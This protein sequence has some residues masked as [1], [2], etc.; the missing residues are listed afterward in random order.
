[1]EKGEEKAVEILT[2]QYEPHFRDLM[3]SSSS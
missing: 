1:M 2:M 3:P